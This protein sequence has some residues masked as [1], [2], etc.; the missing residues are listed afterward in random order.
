MILLVIMTVVLIRFKK[1]A[2][3]NLKKL[4]QNQNFK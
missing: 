3:R 1:K 2:L 4:I